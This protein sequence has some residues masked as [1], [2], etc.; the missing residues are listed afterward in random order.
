M[1][2]KLLTSCGRLTPANSQT[3]TQLLTHFPY[4]AGWG[5]NIKTTSLSSFPGSISLLHSQLLY[6]HPEQHRVE[7]GSF[8]RRCPCSPTTA[9][10]L[11]PTCN[12]KASRKETEPLPQLLPGC[13]RNPLC[14]MV[15]GWRPSPWGKFPICRRDWCFCKCVPCARIIH[16]T[17]RWLWGKILGQ[18]K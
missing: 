5:D 16:Q 1:T 6:P 15:W 13:H 18:L 12:I 10:I 9:K 2:S 14:S 7:W 3:P 8:H 17:F 4:S 11:T